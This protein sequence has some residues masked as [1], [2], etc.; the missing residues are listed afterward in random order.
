MAFG[1]ARELTAIADRYLTACLARE[2]QPQVKELAAEVG[3][4]RSH[5]TKVFS[6]IVGESP[7]K[8][9]RRGQIEFAKRL[10]LEA[11]LSA[12]AIAYK[13]G[14]RRRRTFFPSIRAGGGHESDRL[15]YERPPLA[16]TSDGLPHILSLDSTAFRPYIYLSPGK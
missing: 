1:S 11:D 2:D 8:Y 9:L 16:S 10:L 13:S 7:G 4:S 14:F 3:V 12:N 5:F 6:R 15:P